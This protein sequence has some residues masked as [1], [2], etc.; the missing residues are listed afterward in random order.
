MTLGNEYCWLSNGYVAM[1]LLLLLP[2]LA[3]ISLHRAPVVE[4]GGVRLRL[5]AL[6]LSGS[7]ERYRVELLSDPAATRTLCHSDGNK[8]L[9]ED[10]EGDPL[11]L[12]QPDDV[13]HK[14]LDP[15]PAS[16]RGARLDE[17]APSW[18]E[19]VVRRLERRPCFGDVT[20]AFDAPWFL[21]E[22]ASSPMDR[23]LLMP[24]AASRL[25]LI[26]LEAAAAITQRVAVTL[27]CGR[28][29]VSQY[30]FVEMLQRVERAERATLALRALTRPAEG[31]GAP[32]AVGAVGAAPLEVGAAPVEAWSGAGRLVG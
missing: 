15:G 26:G 21:S 12:G 24:Q 29:D 10:G 9:F 19:A 8:W 14:A 3:I 31:K 1:L 7:L 25:G 16:S 30:A 5:L 11:P 23:P 4:A 2:G 6:E 22:L 18:P 17:D 32:A 28:V 13:W 20:V 27:R